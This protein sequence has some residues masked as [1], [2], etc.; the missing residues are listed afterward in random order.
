MMMKSLVIKILSRILLAVVLF[1]VMN[2]V[3]IK[4]FYKKDLDK[5]CAYL[6]TL[7]SV[8]HES[9]ILYFGESSNFTTDSLDQ[10]KSKISEFIAA[11]DPGLKLG[12][13][14]Y[15]AIHAGI[16]NRLIRQIHSGST[17]KT[18]IITMNLRSFNADWI[19]SELETIL[20]RDGVMLAKR[21]P[22]LNRFLLGLKAYENKTKEEREVLIHK[23]WRTE[24]LSFEETFPYKNVHEWDSAVGNGSFTFP[25]GSWDIEKILLATSYIK[26]YGF[27]IDVNTNPRIHDFDEIVKYA[28]RRNWNLVFNLMAENTEKAGELCGRELVYLIRQ[29][30][31]LLMERYNKNGVIVVDNLELVPGDYY[32]DKNWTTEHY[33]EAGRK[34]IAQNVAA[35]LQKI[36]PDRYTALENQN[37]FTNDFDSDSGWHSEGKITSVLSR[38][39]KNSCLVSHESPYSSAWLRMYNI[40]DSGKY[41]VADVWYHSGQKIKDSKLVISFEKPDGN[42][43]L[44]QGKPLHEISGPGKIWR[45]ATSCIKIPALIPGDLIKVYVWSPNGEKVYLD[46]FSIRIN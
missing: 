2:L 12:T 36:Y 43:V 20:K 21:P 1:F 27:Q 45:R 46:D 38:S 7:R 44:W 15:S 28:Q 39:G 3:Y 30:R 33:T 23:A 25:D 35:S 34:I 16:Y 40:A 19:H 42:S 9:E 18:L 14:D 29:N 5:T 8:E 10:D 4:F 22:L 11:Y 41:L 26:S 24:N 31:D 37:I 6:N 13:V 17:V 32:I